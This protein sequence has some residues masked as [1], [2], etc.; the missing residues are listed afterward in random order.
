MI[1]DCLQHLKY[2]IIGIRLMDRLDTVATKGT[3]CFSKYITSAATCCLNIFTKNIY[4]QQLF[5]ST[6]GTR[7]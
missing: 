7:S 1:T 3:V 5:Y 6:Q 2:N 4:I